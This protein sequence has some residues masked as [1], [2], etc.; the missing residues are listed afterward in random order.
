LHIGQNRSRREA[1]VARIRK[2]EAAVRGRGGD[3]A[4]YGNI[5]GE[6]PAD[7]V[8][9]ERQQIRQVLQLSGTL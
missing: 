3:R 6:P 9:A 2:P 7:P 5:R 1:L 8:L 4:G